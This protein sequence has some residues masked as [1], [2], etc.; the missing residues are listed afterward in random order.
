MAAWTAFLNHTFPE[1]SNGS[2]VNQVKLK[3][4]YGHFKFSKTRQ[5]HPPES[6]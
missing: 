6:K 3:F 2:G 1:S 4:K 5:D